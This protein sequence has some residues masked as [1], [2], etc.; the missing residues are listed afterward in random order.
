MMN[1]SN[2]KK[3]F[4]LQERLPW[5]LLCG[6]PVCQLCNTTSN[7]DGVMC[8]QC[9]VCQGKALTYDHYRIGCLFTKGYAPISLKKEKSL[10]DN[11]LFCSEHPKSVVH[12]VDEEDSQFICADCIPEKDLSLEETMIVPLEQVNKSKYSEL[13]DIIKD[14]NV[15]KESLPRRKG[16][17]YFETTI[18]KEFLEAH[19]VM[20]VKRVKTHLMMKE[21]NPVLRVLNEI[22]I[23]AN[24]MQTSG[25]IPESGFAYKIIDVAK[26]TIPSSDR[27][28][29]DRKPPFLS[30]EISEPQIKV[31]HNL[32]DYISASDDEPTSSQMGVKTGDR[33]YIIHI[34]TPSSIFVR[35]IQDGNKFIEMSTSISSNISN[36]GVKNVKE[37]GIYALN[38]NGVWYR[39]MVVNCRS[40]MPKVRVIFMDTGETNFIYIDL[41][42]SFL[43]TNEFQSKPPLINAISLSC[44]KDCRYQKDQLEQFTQITRPGTSFTYWIDHIE[45]DDPNEFDLLFIGK[46][47]CL[48]SLRDVCI[49]QKILNFKNIYASNGPVIPKKRIFWNTTEVP[50]C[51]S[52]ESDETH[53]S[54]NRSAR[55]RRTPNNFDK[56]G[57]KKPQ[58]KK[59]GKETPRDSEKNNNYNNV[60]SF[61]I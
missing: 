43:S 44:S 14:I 31:N 39:V 10:V 3:T 12:Y 16:N 6:H 4:D 34:K 28:S 57:G 52:V 36:E 32:H 33:V 60:K 55:T 29:L 54:K 13:E 50:D 38:S 22:T 9:S 47:G 24:F 27:I 21:Q 59:S 51:V 35:R 30:I 45:G 15:Y 7:G 18:D 61:Q 23:S 56:K 48:N 40:D 37:G 5:L 58:K 1:C 2:C 17:T 42:R 26:S 49:Q 46:D 19:S 11:T 53:K 25:G 20:Q 41:L 8:Q